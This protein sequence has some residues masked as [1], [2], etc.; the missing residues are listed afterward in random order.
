[1]RDNLFEPA[2][3]PLEGKQGAEGLFPQPPRCLRRALRRG[4]RRSGVIGVGILMLRL[5]DGD[6]FKLLL[7]R[8]RTARVIMV[9][10]QVAIRPWSPPASSFLH[11]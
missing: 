7:G 5:N 2:G 8:K 3:S 11:P 10:F 4:R 9:A 6:A 1:L